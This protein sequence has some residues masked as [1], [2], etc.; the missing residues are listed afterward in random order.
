MNIYEIAKR[1]GVSIAT[2]SRVINGSGPVGKETK[3]KVL[4]V[5]EETGFT[6]NSFAR[7]LN[8]NSMR[9]I[10]VLCTDFGDPFYSQA[11]AYL[12]ERLRSYGFNMLLVCT[13]YTVE[14]KKR[15]LAEIVNKNVDAVI[16]IGTVFKENDNSHIEE[17]ARKVPVFMVNSTVDADNVY[18][19]KCDEERAAE[20]AVA[21]L[22]AA[23]YR[24]PLYLHSQTWYGNADKIC[25]YRRALTTADLPVD[26]ALI[27]KVESSADAVAM[28]LAE[29]SETDEEAFD[30]VF[31]AN[32]VLA[33]YALKA[34]EHLGISK[35]IIGFNNSPLAEL[36]TPELSSVDNM[37]AAMCQTTVDRVVDV[38]HGKQP[39]KTTLLSGS[40]IRRATF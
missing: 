30:A 14:G 13:G 19:V 3:E 33:A 4:R 37:L 1:C 29:L 27:A 2:V 39:P 34:L 16:L 5:I 15:G 11:V 10:G 21:A 40:L 22:L 8:F 7:G 6:P 38:L 12:E 31:T 36:V 18:S 28:L 20:Q 9:L 32:D 17:T 24:K 35:P 26:E 25:G 23:G